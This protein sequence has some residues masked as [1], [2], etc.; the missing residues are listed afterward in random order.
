MPIEIRPT[1]PYRPR[2]P[3][4]DVH[5]HAFKYPQRFLQM[6]GGYGIPAVYGG[7]SVEEASETMA[8]HGIR[9]RVVKNFAQKPEHVR[10]ANDFAIEIAQDPRYSS[11]I[12]TGTIHLG[13]PDNEAEVERLAE[14]G[15][16]GIALD[17]CWQGFEVSSPLLRAVYRRISGYGMFVIAHTGI[18]PQGPHKEILTWP[19]HI[20]HLKEML[21]GSIIIATHLGALWGFDRI[22]QYQ[23]QAGI[24][25]DISW[26][27]ESCLIFREESG[28]TEGRIVEIIG[29][30]G[31]DRIV[32]GLESPWSDIG[33]ALEF[34]ENLV[35]DEAW[36]KISHE[37]A[38][39]ELGIEI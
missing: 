13:C 11:L 24:L 4:V 38:V 39:R 28:L 30:L 29:L 32:C 35:S 14:A 20:L 26:I 23:D 7:G 12:P 27:M 10:A 9:V 18:D 2:Y 1:T 8:A 36:R 33:A 31:A 6:A 34:W 3:I 19:E 17:S 37:N 5:A 22:V 21:P 25:F 16:R 15:I